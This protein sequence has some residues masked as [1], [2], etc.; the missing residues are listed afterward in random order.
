[1][2]AIVKMLFLLWQGAPDDAVNLSVN[3]QFGQ[4][5]ALG[6]VGHADGYRLG[7]LGQRHCDLKE[8][9]REQQMRGRTRKTSK[10]NTNTVKYK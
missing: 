2:F 5:A 10:N 7:A 9:Q 3:V 1:M 4:T 8:L 6:V